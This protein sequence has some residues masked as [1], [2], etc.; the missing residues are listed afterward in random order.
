M[1]I[2]DKFG[3]IV[4]YMVILKRKIHFFMDV[5]QLLMEDFLAGLLLDYFQEYL[6]KKHI[7]LVLKTVA[8]KLSHIKLGQVVLLLGNNF[9]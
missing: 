9:K 2:E 4:I 1:R 6:L 7:C 8:L 3:F 5:T